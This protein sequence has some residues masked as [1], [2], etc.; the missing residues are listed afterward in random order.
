MKGLMQSYAQVLAAIGPDRAHSGSKSEL[1]LTGEFHLIDLGSVWNRFVIDLES[2]W[3]RFGV[4]LESI[5][6]RFGI[7]LMERFM[8]LGSPIGLRG[9][10]APRVPHKTC[11]N[12]FL[13]ESLMRGLWSDS[14]S[15]GKPYGSLMIEFFR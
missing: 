13:E 4:G 5:W 11:I 12:Q 10:Y 15:R 9:V 2:I 6:D 7:G 3:D 8:R 14:F 1:G